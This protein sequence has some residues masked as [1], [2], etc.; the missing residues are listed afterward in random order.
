MSDPSSFVTVNAIQQTFLA[1]PTVSVTLG[2]RIY[3]QTTGLISERKLGTP[4]TLIDIRQQPSN[5]AFG[6]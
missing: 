1:P 4:L 2:R 3:A 5:L 6:R